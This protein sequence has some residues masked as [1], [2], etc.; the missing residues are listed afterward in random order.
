MLAQIKRNN[1]TM[2]EQYPYVSIYIQFI[3]VFGLGWLL[4]VVLVV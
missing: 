1:A 3:A 2:L 4:V